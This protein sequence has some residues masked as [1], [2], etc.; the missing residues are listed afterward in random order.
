M[1]T[2]L[3]LIF[4]GCITLTA[5][6]QAPAATQKIG[7]AD[8]EYI[9]Q[10]LPDFKRVTD[11]MATHETQLQNQLKAK[12]QEL[13]TKMKAYEQNQATMV[14]AVRRSTE[15][16]LRQLQENLQKFSQD[17]QTSYMNK[18]TTLMAPLFE[19]VSKAIEEVA[20]ENGY[21]LILAPAI[22]SQGGAS[23]I[24]LYSS[25]KYDITSLVLKKLGVT[26][27]PATPPAA[28]K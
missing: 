25:E 28:G 22:S 10:Q 14:D 13:E 19:K 26:P 17:A 23:D 20:K 5:A 27:K 3:L 24:L 21:D 2:L 12:S 15:T 1:R 18:Q 4:C 16:E 7:Y 8:G 11:D 6:A 9:I